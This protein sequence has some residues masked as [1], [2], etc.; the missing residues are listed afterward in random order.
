MRFLIPILLIVLLNTN[1][2]AQPEGKKPKFA[3]AFTL[4]YTSLSN[5][6]LRSNENYFDMVDDVIGGISANFIFDYYINDKWGA[7]FNYLTSSYTSINNFDNLALQYYEYNITSS[8][9]GLNISSF[10]FGAI[11][12]YHFSKFALEPEFILGYSYVKPY[13]PDV[14]MKKIGYNEMILM[15]NQ[16]IKPHGSLNVGLVFTAKYNVKRRFGFFLRLGMLWNKVNIDYTTETIYSNSDR[17]Y[18]DYKIYNLVGNFSLNMGIYW[19][20]IR[21]KFD[22]QIKKVESGEFIDE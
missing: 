10:N 6:K 7:E 5:T 20:I 14:K 21:R 18:T 8:L 12:R 22:T 1:L 3:F 4:G 17:T 11:R 13:F 2:S 19:N 9:Y 16:N 15:N